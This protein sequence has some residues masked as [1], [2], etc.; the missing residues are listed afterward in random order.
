MQ[1]TYIPSE[2]VN[3]DLG[4]V[5]AARVSLAKRSTW[6]WNNPVDE[7]GNTH[8]LWDADRKL[9]TYLASYNHWTPFAHSRLYFEIDWKDSSHELSFYRHYNPGG[10]SI[11]SVEGLSYIKGSL[12]SWLSN[13]D[14]FRKPVQESI[15]QHCYKMYPISTQALHKAEFEYFHY[16]SGILN[17]DENFVNVKAFQDPLWYK[18]LTATLLVKVPIFIARQIR[19]SQVG[20]SYSDL[21]VEGESFIYN[22][23]SRRYVNDIPEFYEIK[24]WRVRE[25]TSIK[26]GSTGLASGDSMAIARGMNIDTIITAKEQ[27]IEGVSR[28]IAPE[29]L[30]SL[31][32]QSMYTEFYMT[33]TLHRW[34]QW[35]DLRMKPDVQYET[36]ECACMIRDVLS[37]Q[38]P[39]W[40]IYYALSSL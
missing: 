16:G 13:I 6:K 22:E 10:F 32:P 18:L 11:I 35:V 37:T 1:V 39:Q 9:V 28:H 8:G 15:L 33:A 38:F 31:L 24:D 5:N 25:G 29:Q 14:I 30:R 34:A 2:E 26:Q 36:R 17:M 21:Y 4:V 12:Y 27:Y 7:L 3:S 23:V 19:T 40:A 20:I